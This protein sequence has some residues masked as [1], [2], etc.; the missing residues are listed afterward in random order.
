MARNTSTPG[1]GPLED[2]WPRH[3]WRPS[4]PR[5]YRPQLPA[6]NAHHEPNQHTTQALIQRHDIEGLF[7]GKI[8]VTG[9]P[10]I[11]GLVNADESKRRELRNRLGIAID[12]SKPVVLYA[13]TWR[14]ESDDRY[15]DAARLRDDLDAMRG[16][17]HHVFFRAHRLT[18]GLLSGFDAGTSIVPGD[19]DT[20]DLLSAVDVLI[21]DYSSIFFDF[22]P[23]GRPIVFYAFDLED[24]A[25][26]R[27]LYFDMEQ[28]PGNLYGTGR[29]SRLAFTIR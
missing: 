18:E 10:R 13:P 22:L 2:S 17:D 25:E 27:G 1:T 26:N 9:S 21:T 16:P 29:T 19:I 4:G 8:A 23:T 6:L 3:G 14:G 12:D 28:M 11:D 15:V 5:Q 24:Y 7:R 20:N